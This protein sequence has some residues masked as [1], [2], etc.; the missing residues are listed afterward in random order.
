[1]SQEGEDYSVAITGVDSP[2]PAVDLSTAGQTLS[3]VFNLTLRIDNN[4]CIPGRSTLSLSYGNTFLGKGSVPEFCST[5]K[6]AQ[7]IEI[8]AWGQEVLVPRFLRER[9]AGELERKE[10]AVDIQVTMPPEC[11]VCGNWVLT[12]S[13]AKIGGDPSPCR[14]DHVYAPSAPVTGSTG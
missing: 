10:A 9:M 14:K 3:P 5:K 2:D 13:K 8:T 12:C 6:E 1:M 11:H 4:G 7:E